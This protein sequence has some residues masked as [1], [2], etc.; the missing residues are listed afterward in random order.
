MRTPLPAGT[1]GHMGWKNLLRK[2]AWFAVSGAALAT[3]ACNTMSR[4]G[5]T[6]DDVLKAD[7]TPSLRGQSPQAQSPMRPVGYAGGAAF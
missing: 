2:A 3:S 7:A 1:V 4:P 6:G 5:M